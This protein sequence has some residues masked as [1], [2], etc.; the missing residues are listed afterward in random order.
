[1]E[2]LL[3]M[4]FT[5]VIAEVY[6]HTLIQEREFPQTVA[7]DFPLKRMAGEN[8][9]V[10]EECDTG[11]RLVTAFTNDGEGLGDMSARKFNVVNLT[12]ALDFHLH[13]FRKRVHARHTHAVKT[14]RD[15]VVRA[16]KLTARMEN[17]E[18]H[19][20][21]WTMLSRV[22]IHRNAATIIRHSQGAVGINDDINLRTI[23][24]QS[25]VNRVIHHLVNKVVIAAF[26]RVANVHSWALAHSLHTFQNLDVCRVVSA[27]ARDCILFV[28]HTCI[29]YQKLALLW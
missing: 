19:L 9:V 21:R 3:V 7:K 16:I 1:M 13:P 24:R 17:R 29:L 25:L 22:H 20:N 5:L 15:L 28:V 27:L 8:R 2:G 12:A 10:R 23:A 11:T 26:T 18:H 6:R 14:T 4:G